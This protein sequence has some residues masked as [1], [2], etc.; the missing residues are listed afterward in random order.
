MKYLLYAALRSFA[1]M[2]THPSKPA[3]ATIPLRDIQFLHRCYDG[4]YYLEYSAARETI[5]DQYLLVLKEDNKQILA[6]SICKDTR[7]TVLIFSS[8]I[9]S[10]HTLTGDNVGLILK[11]H[12]PPPLR[13]CV[14]QE[15]SPDGAE[16]LHSSRPPLHKSPLEHKIT[17]LSPFHRHIAPFTWNIIRLVFHHPEDLDMFQKTRFMSELPIEI[18]R[19]SISTRKHYPKEHTDEINQWYPQLPWGVAFQ[20]ASLLYNLQLCAFLLS[21]LKIQIQTLLET[22]GALFTEDVIRHLSSI[23]RGF[24]D[25]RLPGVYHCFIQA[26]ENVERRNVYL[27]LSSD[28]EAGPT[29]CYHV[30][31][32]PFGF[33]LQTTSLTMSNRIL[34][35][36]SDHLDHFLRVSFTDEQGLPLRLKEQ[37]INK[38]KFL[39]EHV[40]TIMR[41]G[42]FFIGRHY[43]YLHYSHSSLKELAFW[44]MYPFKVRGRLVGADSIRTSIGM[45]YPGQLTRCPARYGARL[46]QAFTATHASIIIDDSEGEMIEVDDVERPVP[47]TDLLTESSSSNEPVQQKFYCFTDGVGCFSTEMGMAIHRELLFRQ[48]KIH[49]T[50]S[51]STILSHF[52][53]PSVYQIRI[54]GAKGIIT[55]NPLLPGRIICLRPSM[56]KFEV[57]HYHLEIARSFDRTKRVR[58]NKPLIAILYGRGVPRKV[59]LQLQREA[60]EQAERAISFKSF[61]DAGKC[62]DMYAMGSSFGL[63]TTLQN[64]HKLNPIGAALKHPFMERCMQVALYHMMRALKYK[65]QIPVPQSWKLVGTIDEFSILES[66]EIF[67]SVMENNELIE[68]EGKVLVYK[69]PVIHPGDVQFA[70]AV[71]RKK[72]PPD[73]PLLELKDCV[74]FSQKGDRPLP[75]KCSGSDLDGDMY[76][77]IAFKDL[78]PT[79]PFP[80]MEYNPTS[81]NKELNHDCKV[82]DI[83]NFVLDFILND[84]IGLISTNF[85]RIAEESGVHHPDCRKLAHLHSQAVDFSKTGLPVPKDDIPFPKKRGR[86]PDYLKPE[87]EIDAEKTKYYPSKHA[88]GHLYRNV[89]LPEL[90]ESF[91]NDD[92]TMETE[93]ASTLAFYEE[94]TLHLEKELRSLCAISDQSFGQ[95]EINSK[96]IGMNIPHLL[97]H[98]ISKMQHFRDSYM[99]GLGPY[100]RGKLR[101]EEIFV[102]TI[103]AKSFDYHRRDE[104]CRSLKEETSHLVW[105]IWTILKRGDDPKA[106]VSTDEWTN[107]AWAAWQ[108]GLLVFRTST[109]FSIFGLNSFMFVVLSSLFA[110]I[111]EGKEV[112]ES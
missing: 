5:F 69:S 9:R 35:A 28:E 57:P 101:E 6:Q 102:G 7:R 104:L 76:D 36:H 23:L 15:A 8:S 85:L 88:L 47:R 95:G 105:Q 58:L 31:I 71:S 10:F 90:A 103:L 33:N 70:T 37:N 1:T 21:P 65:M 97:N 25:T 96:T 67:V 32:M 55:L 99:L 42:F 111:K 91:S 16:P 48:G 75:N 34:R 108:F 18:G 92:G 86:K 26:C 81:T 66:D 19:C 39:H 4:T 40:G 112:R 30:D 49:D 12:Y 52:P 110:V 41:R 63:P 74:V 94:T 62:L 20:C 53:P 60:I 59:F 77:I 82:D 78:C 72:L 93:Y 17:Q 64:L 54:G 38:A 89:K 2:Q 14:A 98:F 29:K 109:A 27:G 3:E 84:T 56:K 11:L 46:A 50:I 73:C 61:D 87:L 22:K 45:E 79:N 51:E 107:R 24:E 100:G 83:I 13:E 106:Q 80:P 68:V 44:F 43:Q